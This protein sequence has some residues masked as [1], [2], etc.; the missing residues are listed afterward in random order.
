MRAER[1]SLKKSLERSG[2]YLGWL[3]MS[4]RQPARTNIAAATNSSR[5]WV[6]ALIRHLPDGDRAQSGK[7]F[8]ALFQA[9]LRVCRFD[10]QV[11]LVLLSVLEETFH[12]E[13]RMVRQRQPIQS[14]HGNHRGER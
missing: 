5:D 3:C 11:E 12:V 4:W 2:T 13:H 7:E 6:S 9:E 8:L 14:Q 1:P 10:H